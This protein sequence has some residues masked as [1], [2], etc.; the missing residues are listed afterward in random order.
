MGKSRVSYSLLFYMFKL[1]F[2]KKKARTSLVVQW[3]RLHTSNA[4]GTVS[5]PDEGNKIPKGL[6][7][8]KKKKNALEPTTG[9]T[10]TA[11]HSV[12]W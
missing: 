5:I 9:R 8:K 4:G 11:V 6:G 12:S 3:L 1:L 10:I 2:G 7:K